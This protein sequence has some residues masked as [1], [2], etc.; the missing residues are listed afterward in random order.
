MRSTTE[1][2]AR[3]HLGRIL[4]LTRGGTHQFDCGIGKYHAR[5]DD[6]QLQ[7]AGGKNAAVV[8]YDRNPGGLT[9]DCETTRQEDD[10]DDE[11]GHQRCSC[12]GLRPL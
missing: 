3:H 12:R 1:L 9:L 7:G 11:E 4:R 10:P 5:R 6:H 8:C 2:M